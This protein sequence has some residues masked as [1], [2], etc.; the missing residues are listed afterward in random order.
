[1]HDLAG[2]HFER[3]GPLQFL[4]LERLIAQDP[5][6]Q[7]GSHHQGRQQTQTL[8]TKH[9]FALFFLGRLLRLQ[10][11][12]D[13]TNHWQGRGPMQPR[14][15]YRIRRCPTHDIIASGQYKER[16]RFC[17]SLWVFRE[18]VTSSPCATCNPK[19]S[20]RTTSFYPIHELPPQHPKHAANNNNNKN[21]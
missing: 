4:H 13:T 14:S 17:E 15:R 9:P 8:V 6:G 1:M 16:K 2:R 18:F 7:T 11:R 21:D 5:V 3:M 12:T 20:L 10:H 19:R